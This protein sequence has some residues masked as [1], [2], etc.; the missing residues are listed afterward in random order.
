[1]AAITLPHDLHQRM[2][3]SWGAEVGVTLAG[4]QVCVKHG[5][6]DGLVVHSAAVTDVCIGFVDE[7]TDTAPVAGDMVTVW[8]EGNIVF[9]VANGAITKGDELAPDAAGAVSTRA[10]GL[11]EKH[12]VGDAMSSAGDTELVAVKV[13]IR[14]VNSATT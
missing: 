7:E 13:N 8:A 6:S 1:M 2:G 11:G 12:I 5:A 9:C 10:A 14:S 3:L 4:A